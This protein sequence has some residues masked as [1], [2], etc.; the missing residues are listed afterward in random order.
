M[1][2]PP[3]IFRVNSIWVLPHDHNV[4]IQRLFMYREN[5]NLG[6]SVHVAGLIPCQTWREALT[7]SAFV[8]IFSF[9]ILSV[10][11]FDGMIGNTATAAM[12]AASQ[13]DSLQTTPRTGAIPTVARMCHRIGEKLG[14]VSIEECLSHG[15]SIT[16]GLSVR[17]QPILGKEY[18]SRMSLS[19]IRVLLFGGIHGDEYSSVSIVF[20]WMKFLDNHQEKLFHWYVVP[21]LNPD[22]LLQKKSQRVNANDV[23]LNRNFPPWNG[24]GK[25]SLAYWNQQAKR[26][27]R[28]YPGSNPLSEPETRWLVKKIDE[29][30]P[31]VIIAL[32]AP[33][34]VVDFDGPPKAPK[35]LGRLRLNLLGTYPGSLGNYAALRRGIPVVTLELRYAG[36]LPDNE[37]IERIW[38]DLIKWLIKRFRA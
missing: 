33:Y 11:F 31:D 22:G 26:N 21:L 27:P 24:N 29:F 13:L 4:D 20:K 23:D 1:A 6:E 7:C 25:A 16:G 5:K 8:I 37:E 10:A 38:S 15:L 14:S 12:T 30:Q 2:I 9:L 35:K 36:I 28:R 3:F 17:R 34:G 32:H 19:Q 18:P